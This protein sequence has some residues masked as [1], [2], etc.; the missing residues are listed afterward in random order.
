MLLLLSSC[1]SQLSRLCCVR[2]AVGKTLP[3]ATYCGLQAA[4]GRQQQWDGHE[5]FFQRIVH[6][7]QAFFH[8]LQDQIEHFSRLVFRQQLMCVRRMTVTVLSFGLE[9]IYLAGVKL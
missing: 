4:R 9:Q 7:I 2:W 5:G 8:R 1:A 3:V 6:S